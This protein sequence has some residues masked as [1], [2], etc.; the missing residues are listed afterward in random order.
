MREKDLILVVNDLSCVLL[1]SKLLK[2]T[3]IIKES[4]SQSEKA[5][6]MSPCMKICAFIQHITY[7]KISLIFTVSYLHYLKRKTHN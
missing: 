1:Y 6:T 7:D 4:K 2:N 3:L 5:S